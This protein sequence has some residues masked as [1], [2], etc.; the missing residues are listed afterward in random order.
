MSPNIIQI[1]KAFIYKE[2]GSGYQI[3]FRVRNVRNPTRSQVNASEEIMI[4]TL[5]PK[6]YLIDSSENIGFKIGCMQPCNTC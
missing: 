2:L 3:G 1:Q 4:R 6:G 5:T